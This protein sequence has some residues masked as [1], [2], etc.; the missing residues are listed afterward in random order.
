MMLLSGSLLAETPVA[1]PASA[2]SAPGKN[3]IYKQSAGKPR[4]LEIYFPPDHAPAR[5]KV[6]GVILFH[7][8]G[9]GSG[10]LSVL[11]DQCRY[12]AS[13][14]LVAITANYRMLTKEDMPVNGETK[15]GVCI[16]DAKSAIRWFK[17]HAS[18][19]GV[20]PARIIT[21]GSSAGGHIAMLATLNP[22]LN[23]PADSLG[24]DTS[25]VAY[26]LFNP[27]FEPTDA[28]R[29]PEADVLRF[30]RP[31]IAPAIVF[32]GTKD[33]WKLGW[34]GVFNK[35]TDLGNTT[36][37]LLLAEGAGH[38]FYNRVPRWKTQTLIACDR[39]LAKLGLLA[40]EPTLTA[41]E[42]GE[43]LK[44]GRATTIKASL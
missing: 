39:F 28:V 18:E 17:Q 33:E 21:G 40:G 34:D 8:G 30:L 10:D 13:R 3:Y 15:K 24:V 9:W 5:T 4:E 6:P 43:P 37:E 42:T 22:G 14:G 35:L 32:F 7:G 26:L 23:D 29:D 36:T 19:L 38:T 16:T 25:V 41:P 44:P 11:R 27:A 1:E 12:L 31:D 20:D 2:A